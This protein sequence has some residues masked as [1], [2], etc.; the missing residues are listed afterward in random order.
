[1][2][3]GLT[4]RPLLRW[5]GLL[6]RL[7]QEDIQDHVWAIPRFRLWAKTRLDLSEC[8]ASDDFVNLVANGH[9]EPDD[10]SFEALHGVQ[11][12]VAPIGD[13]EP[14]LGEYLGGFDTDED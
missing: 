3:K 10:L 8:E 5:P 13:E 1:M 4:P 9:P 7:P 11:E 2:S 14:F 6:P 12:N